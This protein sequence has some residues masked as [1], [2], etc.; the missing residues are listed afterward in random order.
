[1]HR[2]ATLSNLPRLFLPLYLVAFAAAFFL[3][4]YAFHVPA[5]ISAS[6]VYQ[7]NNRI[8]TAVFVAGVAGF[9]WLTNG[10][11]L[12]VAEGSSRVAPWAR[13]LGVLWCVGIVLM[14]SATAINQPLHG[15][16]IYFLDRLNHLNAGETIYR[17]IEFPYGPLPLYLPF[18]TS[19]LLHLTLRQGYTVAWVSVWAIGVWVLSVLVDAIEIA[20]PSRTLVFLALVAQICPVTMPGYGINFSP[21]RF[22]LTGSMALLVF[23]VHQRRGL[24][25]ALI[26]AMLSAAFAASVSPEAAIAFMLGSLIFFGVFTRERPRNFPLWFAAM[27]VAF[28]AIVYVSFRAG[29][30]TV[31]RAFGSGA[32]NYPILPGPANLGVMFVYALAAAA[33]YK[34]YR[35]GRAQSLL[36]YILCI[37][38]FCMPSCFGR[39]DYGH[40][41]VGAMSAI[42]IGV[43]AISTRRVFWIP[44]AA[45]FAV[46]VALGLKD[47]FV[48]PVTIIREAAERNL[49]SPGQPAT[50]AARA[51]AFVFRSLHAE[52]KLQQIQAKEAAALD[53]ERSIAPPQTL[54]SALYIAPF[55]YADWKLQ[56]DMS[57]HVDYGYFH[58]LEDVFQPAQVDGLVLWLN[59]HPE[60]RLVL[61]PEWED[62][63]YTYPEGTPES[64]RALYMFPYVPPQRR[65]MTVL[66]PLCDYIRAHYTQDPQTSIRDWSIWVRR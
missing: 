5:S 54:P 55:G 36:V 26:A 30:Y 7:F 40:M 34:A 10:L 39:A 41:E 22:L 44:L 29:V 21:L 2:S 17:D 27:S 6:Y 8:A 49:F 63:C 43:L 46:V 15:E 53:R 4:P 47:L 11:N 64:I 33:G 18:W 52:S 58:G 32:Y 61:P 62:E 37:S 19:K 1:M 24:R 59:S 3:L 23:R 31:L 45:L 65:T 12:P 14:L 25:A 66:Y 51:S 35:A 28:A 60:R 20:A 13:W 57:G 9:A 42:V 48:P 38:L 16:A 50:P 56:I